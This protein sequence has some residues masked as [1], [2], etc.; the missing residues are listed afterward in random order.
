MF[1]FLEISVYQNPDAGEKSNDFSFVYSSTSAVFSIE[2][3]VE[4]IE[5][6]VAE[7]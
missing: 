6:V 4:K 5:L 1:L 7:N 2:V 3:F